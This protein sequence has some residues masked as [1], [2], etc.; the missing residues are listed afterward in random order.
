MKEFEVVLFV[1][2]WCC[3]EDKR[4][5]QIFE[6]ILLG[7]SLFSW[8]KPGKKEQRDG[9]RKLNHWGRRGWR[10]EKEC[11]RGS[12]WKRNWGMGR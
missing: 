8:E 12:F 6:G 2:V 11:R 3:C 9:L 1:V 5:Q 7:E 4:K 10:R